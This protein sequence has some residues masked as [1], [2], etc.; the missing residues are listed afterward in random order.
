MVPIQV[1]AHCNAEIRGTLARYIYSILAYTYIFFVRKWFFEVRLD[2][3]K[4]FDFS[5]CK[6]LNAFLFLCSN[7]QLTFNLTAPLLNKPQIP[8]WALS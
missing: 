4:N 1:N 5:G 6:F 3:L 7:F 8:G 2:F